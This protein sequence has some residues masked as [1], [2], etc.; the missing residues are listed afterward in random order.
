MS[1]QVHAALKLLRK[2]PFHPQWLLDLGTPKIIHRAFGCVL[3]IGPGNRPLKVLLPKECAYFSLDYPP[4]GQALYDNNPDILGDACS[5]PIRTESV[6]TVLLFE[7]L[8]HTGA[9]ED[10]LSEIHRILKPGGTL[11]MSMPFLYPI[12]DAPHD[13]Q[14]FTSHGLSRRLA[15]QGFAASSPQ[16]TSSAMRTAGL[17]TA[18]ALAGPVNQLL[19]N[20]S[21]ALALL[22]ILATAVT[23]SNLIFWLLDKLTPSWSAMTAGYELVAIKKS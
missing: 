18:L 3:E 17:L 10:V 13:Y 22:P 6:D 4:T 1:T 23:V 11:L 2:T 19:K 20:R 14:R 9:P 12:H 16:A 5:L 7:V 21:P 15:D 8:E